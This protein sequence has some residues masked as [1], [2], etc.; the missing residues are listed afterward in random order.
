MKAGIAHGVTGGV[1][2]ELGGGKFA[3]GG[4]YPVQHYVITFVD[5]PVV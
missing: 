3:N 1:V 5:D 2:A 4:V